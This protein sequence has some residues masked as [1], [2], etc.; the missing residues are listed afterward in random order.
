MTIKRCKAILCLAE[1]AQLSGNGRVVASNKRESVDD[2]HKS[3]SFVETAWKWRYQNRWE[4]SSSGLAVPA[5]GWF[6]FSLDCGDHKPELTGQL[7]ENGR[8]RDRENGL[9]G[10]ARMDGNAI[11][12][13]A[14]PKMNSIGS[15]CCPCTGTQCVYRWSYMCRRQTRGTM[16]VPAVK[17]G[18]ESRWCVQVFCCCIDSVTCDQFSCVDIGQCCQ[19][20]K[21][22]LRFRGKINIRHDV[23]GR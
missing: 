8:D 18:I 15:K 19:Q 1:L 2:R 14:R 10:Q 7:V 4:A 20:R 6:I 16:P 3:S 9:Y 11:D 12:T 23:T 21:C 17:P 5:H 22:V 13:A